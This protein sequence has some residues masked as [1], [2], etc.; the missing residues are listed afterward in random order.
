MGLALT[1]SYWN[2]NTGPKGGYFGS[3]NLR[4]FQPDLRDFRVEGL[5]DIGTY[6]F[7]CPGAP[8]WSCALVT[9][10]SPSRGEPLR[11]NYGLLTF[12]F[13]HLAQCY[14]SPNTGR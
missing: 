4:W 9:E 2:V 13:Q 12:V 7:G 1:A 6:G 11:L 3:L 8:A 14:M 5:E 10:V